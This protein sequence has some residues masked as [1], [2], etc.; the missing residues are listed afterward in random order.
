[1]TTLEPYIQ[2]ALKLPYGFTITPGVKYVSFSRDLYSSMNQGSGLP[3][4]YGQTWTKVLPSLQIH[5]KI[6]SNW[7][8]YAQYAQGFLA[9]NLNSFY[10]PNLT[11]ASQP[12]PQETD[13]YQIGT[14]YKTDR[15]TASVDL[16]Y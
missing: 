5:E 10:I 16:Y 7:S 9:P 2:Y 15:V 3:V 14:T 13:N 8:A 1:L 6:N 4:D 12:A 11:P